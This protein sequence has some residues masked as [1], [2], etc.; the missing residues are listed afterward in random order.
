MT[1]SRIPKILHYC[2]GFKEDFGGRA[3]GLSHYACVKSAVE[4]IEPDRVNFYY[5]Y[6]LEGPWWDLTRE[7]VTPVR[8][9]APREIFGNRI[10]HPAH[11]SDVVRLERL[12]EEGGIYLDADV[13]VQRSFDPLLDNSVVMGAEGRNARWGVANAVIAAEPGAP[14]LRRWYDRYRSFRGTEKKYWNEHS[15]RLP[16]KLARQHPDEITILPH[17]AFFWP[18]WTEAHI[19]WMFE[20]GKPVPLDGAY[21]NHLWD[22]KAYFYLKDLTPGEVRAVDTNF[23]RWVRPYV[24][25]LPDD[26]GAAGKPRPGQVRTLSP[27]RRIAGLAKMHLRSIF[28]SLETIWQGQG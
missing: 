25:D 15:V 2:F 20:S 8:M 26:H 16:Q 3:W 11:R 27:L 5:E 28:R 22:R 12:I 9:T 10:D 21:A 1:G 18:L 7:L 13:L 4:Q 24:A 6:E 17:T 19:H 23:H 14:F